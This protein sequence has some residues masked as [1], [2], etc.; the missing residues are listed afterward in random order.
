MQVDLLG[1]ATRCFGL[2]FFRAVLNPQ[3]HILFIVH[4]PATPTREYFRAELQHSQPALSDFAPS[5]FTPMQAHPNHTQSANSQ[6]QKN[7]LSRG[8]LA[9]HL[10]EWLMR[11]DSTSQ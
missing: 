2:K 5:L 4:P 6:H 7:T 10:Q 1:R 9:T 11:R 3:Q 8:L